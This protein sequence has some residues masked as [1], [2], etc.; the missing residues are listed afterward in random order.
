MSKVLVTGGSGFIANHIIRLLLP[1]G[2]N[3][4]TTVRSHDKGERV[5]KLLGASAGSNLTYCIV[6]DVAQK[7]A[8]NDAVKIPDLAYVI[9]TTSPFHYNVQDPVKDMLEP[10][11]NGTTSILQAVKD[12]AP[13]VKRV[14]VL[15]SFAAIRDDAKDAGTTF[16]ETCWNPVTWEEAST[17]TKKTYQGSKTLAERAAWDFV[18]NEKPT[19]ELVTINPSLVFGPPSHLAQGE[20][21][22]LNTSNQRILD[23]LQGKMKDKLAPTGFYSWVDV[24]DVAQAHVRA[25]EAPEAAG[26]RFFLINDYL[27][28]KEIAQ[29]IVE[30]YPE[31]ANKLPGNLNEL[32]SDIPA[33]ESRYK[34]DNSQSRKVLGIEYAPLSKS[35]DDTVKSMIELG[36]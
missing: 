6:K 11:V 1:Q 35:V 8:F 19:F 30:K 7:G 27:T 13:T 18:K 29:I 4:I 31:Y 25:L 14:V 22:S 3:V 16:D 26:K 10:A 33:P 12:N 2:Y 15:S 21:A 34:F 28:N 17:N 20:L 5:K 36:A 32:E 24:R 23:M 9:H